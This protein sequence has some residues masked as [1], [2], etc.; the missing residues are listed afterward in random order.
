MCDEF[1]AI[2]RGCDDRRQNVADADDL[3]RRHRDVRALSFDF[4]ANARDIGRAASE[5]APDTAR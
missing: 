2:V 5:R 3:A 4:C 1:A